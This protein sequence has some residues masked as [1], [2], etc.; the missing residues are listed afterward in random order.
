MKGYVGRG[1]SNNPLKIPSFVLCRVGGFE[2][3]RFMVI[4]KDFPYNSELDKIMTPFESRIVWSE[5]FY[6]SN[7]V[8]IFAKQSNN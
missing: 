1:T 5:M 4:F 3:C 8:E 6:L 7:H 2:Q